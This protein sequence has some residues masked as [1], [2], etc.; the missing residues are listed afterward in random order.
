MGLAGLP[1]DRL[2]SAMLVAGPRQRNVQCGIGGH[3]MSSQYRA[4]MPK[5]S[6]SLTI[7][8]RWQAM[9]KELAGVGIYFRAFA[10]EW[11]VDE[12]TLRRDLK[13]FKAMGKRIIC[14]RL[15]YDARCYVHRYG[16]CVKPLFR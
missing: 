5:R 1:L 6:S 15:G 13:V 16:S 3:F 9:D 7:L 2:I 10:R 8:K 14:V 4:R 11:T 12:K